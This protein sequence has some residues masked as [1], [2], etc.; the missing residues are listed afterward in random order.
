[1]TKQLNIRSDEAFAIAH[2][3][4]RREK[5]PV[6]EVV[7]RA[8]RA[9]ITRVPAL[10]ELSPAQRATYEAITEAARK[11]AATK[12]PGATSDHDDLYDEF[13]LPK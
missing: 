10:D 6:S 3:I 5:L 1:M 4:A 2:E 13:G 8:L 11:A 7:L 12:K 9:K